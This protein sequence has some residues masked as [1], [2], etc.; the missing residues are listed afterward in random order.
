[1]QK[2]KDWYNDKVT[3]YLSA[4][5]YVQKMEIKD[6]EK[7]TLLLLIQTDINKAVKQS[8]D[9]YKRETK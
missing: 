3:D 1:M 6:A 4:S 9:R 2:R 5:N 7:K 8:L